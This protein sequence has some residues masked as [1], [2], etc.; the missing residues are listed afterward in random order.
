MREFLDYGGGYTIV[1]IYHQIP[2]DCTFKR[3]KIY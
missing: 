1:D 2:W 3:S